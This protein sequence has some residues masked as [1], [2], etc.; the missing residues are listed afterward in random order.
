[1][2]CVELENALG[3]GVD[4]GEGAGV[5]TNEMGIRLRREAEARKGGKSRPH[6]SLLHIC[7]QSSSAALLRR[8]GCAAE[9]EERRNEAPPLLMVTIKNSTQGKMDDHQQQMSSF[10]LHYDTDMHILTGR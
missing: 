2:F 8:N 10:H 3:D 7:M 6:T 1:M 4:I 9:T 5:G